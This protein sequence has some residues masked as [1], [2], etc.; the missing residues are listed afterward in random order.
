MSQDILN[1]H[2]NRGHDDFP[3]IMSV[4]YLLKKD[5]RYKCKLCYASVKL[6]SS[7]KT[8][9]ARH[10]KEDVDKLKEPIAS[11]CFK[12]PCISYYDRVVSPGLLEHHSNY[13]HKNKSQY[14]MQ[15][16]LFE[17][18][19]KG[20][21]V[22]SPKQYTQ[23][24]RSFSMWVDGC[25]CSLAVIFREEISNRWNSTIFWECIIVTLDF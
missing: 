24:S 6:Y 3:L 15:V 14:W 12:F 8:H 1:F 4:C 17:I 25:K 23:T 22:E 9:V 7:L 10:G 5:N 13:G 11:E 18:Q 20:V 16:L 2:K 21:Y 19:Q